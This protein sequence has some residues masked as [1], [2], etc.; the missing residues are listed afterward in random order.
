[1]TLA[2]TL[3]LQVRGLSLKKGYNLLIHELDFDLEPGG[4][5]SL[6]G[7][8]GVGKTTLLRTLAGF[9]T[10]HTGTVT[11]LER[12]APVEAEILHS[13]MIHFL[14]HHDA[15]SPS[16]TVSQELK[17]QADFL[18]G[19][20]SGIEQLNLTPLLDLETRYLSAGQKR[21]LSFARLLMAKR[22]IWLLD[23]PMAPLDTGHRALMAGLMQKHLE[24]GG[25]LIAAVHDPLPFATRSL[26]LERPTAKER[27]AESV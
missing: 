6:T 17:F 9:M 26:R 16:R 13:R 15:L 24:D 14:G 7:E 25:M 1:M 19:D 27:E 3:S 21:R 22:P 2:Y 11:A 20:V 5:I 8:N 18:G 10:P 4:A 23:E 12:G